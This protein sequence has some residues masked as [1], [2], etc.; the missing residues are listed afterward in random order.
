MVKVDVPL[1][2]GPTA[3]GSIGPDGMSYVGVAPPLDRDGI[4][5]PG[6]FQLPDGKYLVP[7]A[8]GP[9]G[10][11]YGV[12]QGDDGAAELWA[13]GWDGLPRY[14]Y[15]LPNPQVGLLVPGPDSTLL[16]LVSDVSASDGLTSDR[17][18]ALDAQGTPQ[19]DSLLGGPIVIGG[20]GLAFVLRDDGSIL[21]SLTDRTGLCATHVLSPIGLDIAPVEASCWQNFTRSRTGLVAGWSCGEYRGDCAQS[22]IAVLDDQGK[23]APGWPRVVP[24]PIT[25]PTFGPDGSL[26]FYLTSPADGSS[27]L[28]RLGLDGETAPGWPV[29]LSSTANPVVGLPSNPADAPAPV[30]GDGGVV[31]AVSSSAIAAFSPTGERLSGWP[32]ELGV[33]TVQR[34]SYT[35]TASGTGVLFVVLDNRI[36]AIDPMGR[37]IGLL[38]DDAYDRV[39]WLDVEAVDRGVIVLDY[40]AGNN[41]AYALVTYLP[42]AGF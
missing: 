8:F 23:P 39:G 7:Q 9:D 11:A 21:T 36:L 14:S 17:L 42:A 3:L 33:T 20:R 22:T 29:P 19:A 27:S 5:R 35:H 30:I 16:V 13:F 2:G 40:H 37:T 34:L 31:Y 41:A 1:S 24:G 28:T 6:S 10:S 26:Y 18:I 32:V 15:Q 4:Q 12:V 25:G 38:V